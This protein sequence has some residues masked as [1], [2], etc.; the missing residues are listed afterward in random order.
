MCLVMLAGPLLIPAIP[1]LIGPPCLN[2]VD[3][4]F[5]FVHEFKANLHHTVST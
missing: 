3:F 5:D 4:D 2:K 1:V